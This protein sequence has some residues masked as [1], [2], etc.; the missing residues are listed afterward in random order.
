MH[1]ASTVTAIALFGS[2]AY[3]V[4]K[5][6]SHAGGTTEVDLAS[7]LPGSPPCQPAPWQSRMVLPGEGPIDLDG[8]K[9]PAGHLL[10]GYP[11]G[12][13]VLWVTDD[14]VDHQLWNAARIRYG[15]T[16]LWPLL[17][18]EDRRFGPGLG[19]LLPD[20][21]SAADPIDATELLR[22]WWAAMDGFGEGAFPGLAEPSSS[23][24]VAPGPPNLEQL[25]GRRL[26]LAAVELPSD[27][28]SV[29]GFAGAINHTNHVRELTSVVRRW[30]AIFGGVVVGMTPDTLQLW[31]PVAPV[32]LE[33]CR[34]LAGELLAFCPGNIQDG[35]EGLDDYQRTIVGRHLWTFWWD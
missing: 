30:E 23:W 10:A 29:V 3:W 15:A 35:G 13:P 12:L 21:A 27:V 26:G 19:D 2:R 16:G 25:A 9:L 24:Q 14:A 33:D 18:A 28:L 4:W 11:A 1:H 17:V 32:A 7:T 5:A 20:E 6:R 22:G 8:L 31:S 34:R